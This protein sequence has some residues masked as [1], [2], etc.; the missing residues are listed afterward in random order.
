M[1]TIKLTLATL[2]VL[3][4]ATVLGQ[5]QSIGNSANT[6]EVQGK[7]RVK[8]TA[9]VSDTTLY[10][11]ALLDSSG[12]LRKSTSWPKTSSL[13]ISALT[14]ATAT[15]TINN[16]GF[17]QIWSWNTLSTGVGLT[18]NSN[19]PSMANGAGILSLSTMGTTVDNGSATAFR[20]VNNNLGVNTTN[21]GIY[22]SASQGTAANIAIHS[23]AGDV[24]L[25][26]YQGSLVLGGG[27]YS[28]NN[29]GVLKLLGS[30]SGTVT[31]QPATT[32][33][34]WTMTLPT[35]GGAANEVLQ[36]DGNGVTSWA[37]RSD[38]SWGL[39]GN[40]VGSNGKW[41]GTID[42]YDYAIKTNNTTRLLFYANG[43]ISRNAGSTFTTAG[44]D[45][46][47]VASAVTGVGSA[48]FGGA[49]N[50]GGNYSFATGYLNYTAGQRSFAQG[51]QNNA[52]GESGSVFGKYNNSRADYEMAIGFMGTNYTSANNLTDRIFNVGSSQD[53]GTTPAD[54]FTIYK[55]RK[56]KA[57]GYGTGAIT[58]TATYSLQVDASGN[59]IEGAVGGSGWSL[60]GNSGTTAGTDFVGT[61]DAQDVV[62][63]RN[64]VFAGRIGPSTT[65]YGE[66][67]YNSATN[68][69]NSSFG[70]GALLNGGVG[71]ASN[72]AIGFGALQNATTAVGGIA[73]GYRAAFNTVTMNPYSLFINSIQRG[74]AGADTTASIIYGAQ[75][76]TAANQR[77]YLNSKVI[78]PYLPTAVGTKAVRI[79]ASGNLSVADTTTGSGATPTLQQVLTAGSTLTGSN[80]IEGGTNI[81]NWNNFDI[82][83]QTSTGGTSI[84]DVSSGVEAKIEASS[85]NIFL[86]TVNTGTTNGS[87]ITLTQPS[88]TL[89]PN[90]G[91]L[92]IDTLTS[93]PGTKALRYNPTSGLVSYADT[94]T[95]GGS[96]AIGTAITSATAGSVL[97]AGTGGTLQQKNSDFFYDST[98][99]RLGIGTATPSNPLSIRNSTTSDGIFLDGT[100]PRLTI[101]ENTSG[102]NFG[103]LYIHNNI[104]GAY[105]SARTTSSNT[106]SIEASNTLQLGVTG[107]ST[108]VNIKS[109]GMGIGTTSP[110]AVLHLKAGTAAAGT[111]PLKFTTSGAALLTTPE[112]GAIEVLADTLYYTGS[113]G[114][115]KTLAYTTDGITVGTTTINQGITNGLLFKNASNSLQQDSSLRFDSATKILTL[116]KQVI[117]NAGLQDGSTVVSQTKADAGFGS[118]NLFT[119]IAAGDFTYL[120]KFGSPVVN[121]N[122]NSSV[123]D[124][125]PALRALGGLRVT[126]ATTTGTITGTTFSANSINM[127]GAT[128]M[129]YQFGTDGGNN[130]TAHKFQTST[131]LTG[132]TS[133]ILSWTNGTGSNLGSINKEGKMF[134]G[135]T[136]YATANLHI[137]AGSATAN[138]SPLKFTAGTN[139]T[140]PEAG[141]M[142]FDGTHFYGTIGSTRYQ[143]DQQSGG[144]GDMVL[145]NVQTVTGLK[146]FDKDK[147]AMKG[148]ST[149]VT[150]ISTANAGASNY[151][152]TLQAATG[153]IAYTSDTT[154]AFVTDIIRTPGV[155]SFWYRKGGVLYGLKD[156]VGGGSSGITVG[157]TAITSGTSTRIPFNDG[158]VYEEDA[159]LTWDKNNNALSINSAG[160]GTGISVSGT[161]PR[162][163]I[164][165]S[166]T[167]ATLYLENP[168]GYVT[169]LYGESGD[170]TI[171][172]SGGNVPLF[173]KQSNGN[174]GVF[175]TLSPTAKLHIGAA[176]ATAGTGQ[177]KFTNSVLPTTPETGLLNFKD[178]LLFVD[179]STSNRDTIA[180]REWARDN[181]SG[182]GSLANTND[183]TSHTV[184]LTGG[185]SVQ[186]VEGSNITLTTTGT[187]ANGVVTIASTGGGATTFAA[188]TDV[189]LTSITTEDMLKWN[190]TDWINRSPANVRTDLGLV[191]GTNVQAYDAD[192]TTWAGITPA[193]NV[194][195][196]LATPS[197]A[198]LRSAVTDENGTGVLLFD[199]A[200]SPDFATSITIGGV[201]VPTASSTTTFTNK[202]ITMRTGTTTSSATPTINT[203]NVNKYSLTAQTVDITSFTTN[204]SGTPTEGQ[205]LLICVTGTASRAI[206]W[207]A[208][209]VA[210]SIALP[211][212]TSGTAML[213]VQFIYD[214][215]AWRITGY[216]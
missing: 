208:S 119:H 109:T 90:A 105:L 115:R 107:T 51:F 140:T 48:A 196:F 102:N 91:S 135:G 149:G 67:T 160:S 13:P 113:G 74:S 174:V 210:S 94:A 53:G 139:L 80:I 10:K 127:N 126:G 151:T 63:K 73:L 15:N 82:W 58:G 148:T 69:A 66:S 216:Y 100:Y 61:T 85:A 214:G 194:G 98:N 68:T 170:F 8:N 46:S 110:T 86:T 144:S 16:A 49:H 64:N 177:L 99:K 71:V 18:M 189:D 20:A 56:I 111:A 95:G 138:T 92:K 202:R 2:M 25:N 17:G 4:S 89:S 197:S 155:D 145:A 209:F 101:Q 195:T 70:A 132:A 36:T 156:S 3:I 206:T 52:Y 39:T 84:V 204:L 88:I 112:A 154:G 166:S 14:A 12:N 141:A 207:G 167:R 175:N 87:E 79:D 184:T 173:L 7:L 78:M 125:S 62:F 211:T 116:G 179:S 40:T 108:I 183:A 23:Y 32:A 205:S 50:A 96:L 157:T 190:G 130:Y 171:Q 75:D 165:S 41:T 29:R 169:Q 114:T 178:G 19:A 103:Q 47:T 106:G 120:N 83:S 1:K 118:F 9:S 54:A 122:V 162:I 27:G 72:T 136:T 215:A 137:A 143:L 129:T 35:T 213:C 55:N 43:N 159:G 152:A 60:T 146:T 153:T 212:T 191:I 150:T 124:V 93:A 6:V 164:T 121:Y 188:L 30:T 34:T 65:S 172:Q 133:N 117:I 203:D 198:N 28:G 193:A 181:I 128:G 5:T 185:T 163:S 77:L 187:G 161:N 180:T 11:L 123:Y 31:V 76:A 42:N 147:L 37:A 200:T 104:S 38:T 192:L 24:R 45:L 176:T 22:A 21:V 158:G 199:G 131:T 33:G 97:F 59:I 201:P 168:L 81:I 182:G 134:L 26:T 44:L 186:L 142:E 57:Q